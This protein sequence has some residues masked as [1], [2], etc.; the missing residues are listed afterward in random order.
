MWA[1]LIA[2]IV[3]AGICFKTA[4]NPFSAQ[5]LKPGEQPVRV[6]AGSLLNYGAIQQLRMTAV[7]VSEWLG[8]RQ[9]AVTR[10]AARGESITASNNL[11]LLEK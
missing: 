3:A 2:G 7:A 11:K 9:P 10:A 4:T 1:G 5:I 8:I 6:Y